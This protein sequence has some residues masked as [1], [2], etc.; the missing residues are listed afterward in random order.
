MI[1]FMEVID[2][3]AYPPT[4][5]VWS[6]TFFA[7]A[8][9]TVILDRA[10]DSVLTRCAPLCMDATDLDWKHWALT[11]ALSTSFHKWM[12]ENGYMLFRTNLAKAFAA[13]QRKKRDDYLKESLIGFCDRHLLDYATRA[14][15][16]SALTAVGE[17]FTGKKDWAWAETWLEV[18]FGKK[19]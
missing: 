19:P 18:Q 15:K 6:R 9:H 4:S 10:P 11:S 3:T 14:R 5:L 13:D 12:R 8:L 16:R 2:E 7:E 1:H 17:L